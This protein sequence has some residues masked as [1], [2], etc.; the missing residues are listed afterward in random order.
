VR[1]IVL[2]LPPDTVLDA[3]F[4]QACLTRPPGE[5]YIEGLRRY[6]ELL[7]VEL[8]GQVFADAPRQDE[9]WKPRANAKQPKL[10]AVERSE[11]QR[12]GALNRR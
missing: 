4:V 5:P 11:I 1:P 9:E 2:S 3:L 7:L 12:A 8:Q 6:T 10:S